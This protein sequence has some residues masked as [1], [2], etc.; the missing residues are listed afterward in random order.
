MKHM[1]SIKIMTNIVD[2]QEQT[3]QRDGPRFQ[4]QYGK[5]SLIMVQF[6]NSDSEDGDSVG[7]DTATEKMEGQGIKKMY[8]QKN[9]R[10]FGLEK[11][12]D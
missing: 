4:L 11:T 3:D 6:K 12:T 9:G 5:N 8:L 1:Y 10:Y 7:Y 2:I